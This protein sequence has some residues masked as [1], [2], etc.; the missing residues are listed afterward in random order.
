MVEKNLCRFWKRPFQCLNFVRQKFDR[1][2]ICRIGLKSPRVGVLI[3]VVFTDSGRFFSFVF[4]GI[5]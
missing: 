4:P 3:E 5:G 1:Q 2:T